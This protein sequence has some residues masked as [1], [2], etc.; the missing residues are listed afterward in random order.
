MDKLEKGL[1]LILNNKNFDGGSKRIGSDID[2]TNV[3]HVFEEIGYT[4]VLIIDATSEVKC[5]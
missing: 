2:V 3:K 1:V 4:A 5:Y